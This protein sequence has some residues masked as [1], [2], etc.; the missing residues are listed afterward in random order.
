MPVDVVFSKYMEV[1]EIAG[2][3]PEA[4]SYLSRI[5]FRVARNMLDELMRI[6]SIGTDACLKVCMSE[7]NALRCNEG[8]S[9]R[10]CQSMI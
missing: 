9:R 5:P 6:M 2:N 7:F 3:L 1:E 10:R 4:Q 8:G